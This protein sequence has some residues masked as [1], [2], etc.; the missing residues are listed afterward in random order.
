[1]PSNIQLEY[2]TRV[3]RFLTAIHGAGGLGSLV[4]VYH[5]LLEQYRQ[6]GARLWEIEPLLF[7]FIKS[8]E[9]NLHISLARLLEPKD[10]SHGNLQKFFSFCRANARTIKWTDGQLTIALIDEQVAELEKHR[11]TIEYIKARR[12]KRFAHLDRTY[13]EDE[14]KALKDFYIAE[15]DMVTLTNSIINLLGVHEKGLKPNVARISLHI[16][17]AEIVDKMIRNLEAGQKAVLSKRRKRK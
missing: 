9:A 13:F 8:L 16:F 4:S 15:D 6:K 2:E 3:D 10:R 7:L 1:M 14:D 12:D 11:R 17:G 5:Q